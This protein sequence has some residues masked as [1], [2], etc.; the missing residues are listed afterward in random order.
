MMQ[1]Q[2]RRFLWFTAVAFERGHLQGL[3]DLAPLPMYLYALSG[4]YVCE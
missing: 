3:P 4:A 2:G 1:E